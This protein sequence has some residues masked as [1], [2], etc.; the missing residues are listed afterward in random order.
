LG[1]GAHNLRQET[2]V[3]AER[4]TGDWLLDHANY[5]DWKTISGPQILW[6]VGKA[7]SGKST[8][9]LALL[10]KTLR[11]F[12][13]QGLSDM[14]GKSPRSVDSYRSRL[15]AQDENA[16]NNVP[17]SKPIVAAFFYRFRTFAG[18]KTEASHTHM[19]RSI[20]YQILRQDD[21]L[22]QYFREFYRSL[23]TKSP[24]STTHGESSSSPDWSFE[25]MLSIFSAM[26]QKEDF[27][28]PVYIFLDALDESEDTTARDKLLSLIVDSSRSTNKL[29]IKVLVASRPMGELVART[30][31]RQKIVLER[32]NHGDIK[33]I[34]AA[35]LRPIRKHLARLDRQQQARFDLENFGSRLVKKANGVILWISVVLKEVNNLLSGVM[36]PAALQEKLDRLSNST[37]MDSLYLVIIQRLTNCEDDHEVERGKQWIRLITYSERNL[38]VREFQDAVSILSIEARDLLNEKSFNDHKMAIVD[39]DGIQQALVR[40]CGGFIEVQTQEGY[41]VPIRDGSSGSYTEELLSQAG[42]QLLHRTVKDFLLKPKSVPFQTVK[43]D[44]DSLI[45]A[46]CCRYLRV[47]FTTSCISTSTNSDGILT[48]DWDISHFEKF[49]ACLQA[50]PLLEYAFEHLL[51]HLIDAGEDTKL[52]LM[53]VAEAYETARHNR[54]SPAFCIVLSWIEKES[55]LSQSKSLHSH[56]HLIDQIKQLPWLDILLQDSLHLT[57]ADRSYIQQFTTGALIAAA[58][59]NKL[60]AVKI[61]LAIGASPSSVDLKSG[62]S[63][64]DAAAVSGSSVLISLLDT[65]QIETNQLHST[66]NI[67]PPKSI[68]RNKNSYT[69]PVDYHEESLQQKRDDMLLKAAVEGNTT[70]VTYLLDRGANL[71]VRDSHNTSLLHF[72]AIAGNA[73]LVLTLLDAGADIDARDDNG[74]TSLM[75][76]VMNQNLEVVSLLLGRK[77]DPRSKDSNGRSCMSFATMTK[78]EGIIQALLSHG[79]EPEKFFFNKSAFLIPYARS[80]NFVGREQILEAIQRQFE[81]KKTPRPHVRLALTG[82]PGV[83]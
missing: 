69:E 62:G 36:S 58:Q 60:W 61:L 80:E 32:E 46:V 39:L 26:L 31:E 45:S 55:R 6:L 16:G 4:L 42:L 74:H 56:P 65:E 33:R 52:E 23:Q 66:F 72:G 12:E 25:P 82:L 44:G 11:E 73:T 38:S 50:C 1:K 49:I 13:L 83:G 77:A 21:S 48:R 76:A 57:P 51:G 8:I 41:A 2:I 37:D 70:T 3:E 59:A 71:D 20:L 30:N 29:R 15:I 63:A 34:I 64:L 54:F 24:V 68:M 22:F 81:D 53:D 79:A 78:N 17:N 18:E 5:V 19:L 67:D 9:L 28:R 75:M 40:V 7:G 47:F 10:K 14:L 27:R 35:G 43:P